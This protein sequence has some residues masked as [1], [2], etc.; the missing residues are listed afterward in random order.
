MEDMIAGAQFENKRRNEMD[1]LD[2]DPVEAGRIYLGDSKPAWA[3]A[4]FRLSIAMSMESIAE[5]LKILARPQ[6]KP[7]TEVQSIING[8]TEAVEGETVC[9]HGIIPN[10]CDICSGRLTAGN[11]VDT[12]NQTVSRA[13][14]IPKQEDK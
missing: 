14:R 1:K 13:Q 11:W 6:A 8:L 12:H 9:I 7:V 5:S 2:Y 10:D 4:Y 3:S